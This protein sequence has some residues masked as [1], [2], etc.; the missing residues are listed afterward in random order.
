MKDSLKMVIALLLILVVLAVIVVLKTT[1]GKARHMNP[2]GGEVSI[3]T[4]LAGSQIAVDGIIEHTTRKDNEVYIVSKLDSGTHQFSVNFFDYYPW[5][6]DVDVSP[7]TKVMLNSFSTL[8]NPTR[9]EIQSNGEEYQNYR[10][11][12]DSLLIPS[13]ENKL[14]SKDGMVSVWAQNNSI[15]AEWLGETTRTPQAFCTESVCSTRTTVVS[16]TFNITSLAFLGE[17]NDAILFADDQGIYAIE[18]DKKNIQNFQPIIRTAIAQF[19][20][21]GPRS[22]IVESRGD[23]FKLLF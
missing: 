16:S 2:N 1:T 8:Q 12:F 19:I 11:Q 15:F 20:I 5:A 3:Q 21:D 17:H 9:V 14:T 13:E 18:I 4:E 6:K 23:I 7:E 10:K 22:I